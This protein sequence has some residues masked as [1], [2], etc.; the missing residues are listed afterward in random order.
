MKLRWRAASAAL[1]AALL[2]G[3]LSACTSSPRTSYTTASGE[4]VAVDWKDFPAP[5][6][7]EPDQ[8]LRAPVAED[9]ES[10]SAG[11]L[12]DITAALTQEFGLAWATSG[13]SSWHAGA[14]NGY[15]GVAMSTTYNSVSWASGTVPPSAEWARVVEIVNGF[16]SARGL[17][18]TGL[19]SPET[20]VWFGTAYGDTQWVSVEI[21][22]AALAPAGKA[23]SNYAQ[24][25]QPPAAI[26]LSYGATALPRNDRP[27]FIKDL[28]PFAGLERP[29]STTSDKVRPPFRSA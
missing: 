4:E 1:A 3:G 5:S 7:N 25:K 19:E 22:D 28:E 27:A 23:A 15:G 16:A 20:F 14:G 8:L 18:K 10:V 12:T 17:D 24:I 6:G 29:E 13:E 21:H 26:F 9:I 11:I 2:L